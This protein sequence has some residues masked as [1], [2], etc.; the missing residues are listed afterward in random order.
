[1]PGFAKEGDHKGSRVLKKRSRRKKVSLCPVPSYEAAR[2]SVETGEN[3]GVKGW[4]LR[5]RNDLRLEEK[6][7]MD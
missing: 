7:G 1:M 6:V 5:R 4:E 2:V 3:L